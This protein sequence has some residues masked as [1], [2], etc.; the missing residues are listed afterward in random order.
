MKKHILIFL[1]AAIIFINLNGCDKSDLSQSELSDISASISDITSTSSAT[2]SDVLSDIST[3]GMITPEVYCINT[4]YHDQIDGELIKE[5]AVHTDIDGNNIYTEHYDEDGVIESEYCYSYIFNDD[6]SIAREKQIWYCHGEMKDTTVSDYTYNSDNTQV[7]CIEY[8]NGEWKADNIFLYDEHG[9]FVGMR[10]KW[11]EDDSEYTPFG[12]DYEFTYDDNDRIL[13]KRTV[14]PESG[15][16]L[17]ET[18]YNYDESG[19][20][21]NETTEDMKYNESVTQDY[22]YDDNGNCVRL[23][24]ESVSPQET[25]LSEKIYTYDLNNRLTNEKRYTNGE[26]T[27]ELIYEYAE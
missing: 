16:I 2:E 23:V 9:E 21:I 12:C 27:T 6:G 1:S 4:V 26:W 3:D 11:S 20:L 10:T 15:E 14:N 19:L 7:N 24:R 8:E 22:T 5:Y 13:L 18:V 25:I 17:S